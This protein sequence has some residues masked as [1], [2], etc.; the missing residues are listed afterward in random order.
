MYRDVLLESPGNI[1]GKLGN[2]YEKYENSGYL[3]LLKPVFILIIYNY[4]LCAFAV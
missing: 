2:I 3:Q 4:A 1:Q